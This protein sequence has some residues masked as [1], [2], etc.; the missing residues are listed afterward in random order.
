MK[1]PAG[2]ALQAASI[3]TKK[4]LQVAFSFFFL[5]ILIP[6]LCAGTTIRVLD[7]EGNVGWEPSIAINWDGSPVVSYAT[8]QAVG[9]FVLLKVAFCD[10]ADCEFPILT[11]VDR[12]TNAIEMTSIAIDNDGLPVISYRDQ[13]TGLKVAKCNNKLSDCVEGKEGAWTITQVP[14][15]NQGIYSSIAVGHDGL[16]VISY[17]TYTSLR[18]LKCGNASCTSGNVDTLL[19]NYQHPGYTAIAIGNDDLP[20]IAHIWY[21]LDVVKCGNAACTSGNSFT[22]DLEPAVTGLEL[23]IAIGTDGIPV[24]SYYGEQTTD[25]R[26][27]QVP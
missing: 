6:S 25:L 2:I 10:D 16:P 19:H 5:T 8:R 27:A 17:Q 4:T 12:S 14:L 24:I 23:D 26:V 13:N 15:S 1:H 7:S 22:Q 9:G 18:V 21:Q 3:R 11:T 20:V